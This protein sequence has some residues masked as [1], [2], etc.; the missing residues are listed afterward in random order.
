[1]AGGSTIDIA[2][3]PCRDV[4]PVADRYGGAYEHLLSIQQKQHCLAL[5]QKDA[6]I[7]HMQARL[8]VLEGNAPEHDA[9]LQAIQTKD[10]ECALMMAAKHKELEL[11]VG[12]LQMREHQIEDLRS[13]CEEVQLQL[14]T[15]SCSRFSHGSTSP[16]LIPGRLEDATEHQQVLKE[17]RRLRL[18][19][20]ELEASISEQQDRSAL[21]A[22]ELQKKSE[23]VEML[24]KHIHALDLS[25]K[26][27]RI[28][29]EHPDRQCDRRQGPRSND[30]D[31]RGP[32]ALSPRLD[33]KKW[34]DRSQ[35]P[36]GV[37]V[38]GSPSPSSQVESYCSAVQREIE[39]LDLAGSESGRQSQ[40]LL[41]E[42]R[43]L[44]QQMNELEQAAGRSDA[45][46]AGEKVGPFSTDHDRKYGAAFDGHSEPGSL[47]ASA[48]SLIHSSGRPAVPTHVED[49]LSG[50]EYRAQENDPVDAAVAQ[51]VNRGQYRAW[52]A[53]LCRL[54]QGVYLCGTR[55]VYIRVNEGQDRLEASED[56]G[57]SWGDLTQIMT[58]A[59]A[60]QV[61][62]LE[63]AKS[64]AGLP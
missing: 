42:M 57:R 26:H 32:S 3:P 16:F 28:S 41:R 40:E 50:W 43:R 25:E 61:A 30:S 49:S 60:A 19:M 2:D 58:G 44:R 33:E 36:S 38:C 6:Q 7:A 37:D 35:T 8:V 63:R 10:E 18:R 22:S 13:K 56:A 4:A 51:L 24:E 64:A 11:V 12:L 17:V 1:M 29:A 20:E 62:L 46:I 5:E 55:R 47:N 53:L 9:L 31:I 15:G 48:R 27:R 14:S 59:K 34:A 23:H 52:R 39:P 21:L 45:G 54:E